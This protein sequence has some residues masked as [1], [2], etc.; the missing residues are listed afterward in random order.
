M[1]VKT[2]AIF[3]AFIYPHLGGV[4]RFTVKIAETLVKK[5]FK[6]IIVTTNSH[7][8]SKQEEN[9]D[10]KIYRFPSKK[11]FKSRYPIFEK[12]NIYKE[13]LMQLSNENI[14]FVICNTRFYLTTLMGLKIAK[15]RNLKAI[16]IE[17]GGGYVQV[18]TTVRGHTI[19]DFLAKLY[20]HLITFA[21]KRYSPDF[22][23][24]SERSMTWLKN[25]RISP[26]GV[27]YNS[28][29]KELLNN[30]QSKILLPELKNNL[31]ISYAGR[32]IEEKGIILL[33]EAFSQLETYKKIHLAIA[34]DGPLLETL[35]RKYKNERVSF[36]GKLDYNNT[37][38]LMNQSD[39]F[40]NPSIYAE[41]MPTAVL[42]SGMMKCA[43]IATDRGGVTEVISDEKTGIIVDDSVDSIKNALEVLITNHGKRQLLQETIHQKIKSGFTWDVTVKHLIDDIMNI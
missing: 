1:S 17:H 33:L 19:L 35:K 22:F 5:G 32:I 21:V 15:K 42:E 43:V 11:Q 41:G 38:I 2:I 30:Y 25:F 28:I 10:I 29:D 8:L 4:E 3:T 37:M 26:K 39:I 9:G 6:V 24:V 12:N 20:E 13:L 31:I 16:V 14:D 36:L 23:A 7:N 34:G 18:G 40:V 27:I